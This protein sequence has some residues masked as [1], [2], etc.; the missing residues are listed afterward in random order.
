MRT[1]TLSANSSWYLYNF[2][3]STIKEALARNYKVICI[4]PDDEYS[5][6]LASL[7]CKH[8]PLN[9]QSKSKN[10]FSEI[11]LIAK[12]FW[13]YRH[14][15]PDAAFHFTIKNNLYGTI[16]AKINGI[17]S[18]NNI[19][20]LGTAF[21]EKSLTTFIV[22][23]LYKVSQPLAH[24]VYCQNIEDYNLLRGNNLVP[25]ANLKI[26]PGSGVDTQ[27]FH[28][29]LKKNFIDSSDKIFTFLFAGRMLFDKGLR[30]LISAIKIINNQKIRCNLILAGYADSDNPSA[31]S[32][33]EMQTWSKLPGVN[34]IGATDD[35]ASILSQVDCIV[36]PS[37][38]EG[39]PRILL[40]A[41]AMELPCIASNVPGC[42][43]IISHEVNGLLF[44]PRNVA[45]LVESMNLIMNK[46]P[47]DLQQLG[48][49]AREIIIKNFDEIIVIDEFFK[50]LEQ[51]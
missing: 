38:R 37:Y 23:I 15:K 49:N 5:D 14:I 40:E 4:S 8:F 10:I 25:H 21:L 34:W 47:Q 20:G 24:K 44:K 27:K 41:G 45:S 39:M 50:T 26:L 30:E 19:S 6:K 2:R 12:F 51:I 28:P 36:L 43:N 3:S 33:R 32:H 9:F 1:I 48:S 31:V 46:T 22:K 11:L 29:N 35:I 17:P 42:K 16:A 7:G 13:A 18:I